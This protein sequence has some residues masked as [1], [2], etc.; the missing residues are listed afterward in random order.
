MIAGGGRQGSKLFTRNY[1]APNIRDTR[2]RSVF[3]TTARGARIILP[4]EVHSGIIP[5]YEWANDGHR[6]ANLA[7]KAGRD[8]FFKDGKVGYLQRLANFQ[9]YLHRWSARTMSVTGIFNPHLVIGFPGLVID[10]SLPNPAVLAQ[11]EELLGRKWMPVQYLGKMVALSHS[12][13]QGGGQTSAQFTH[14][15]T[16]RGLD[17][18][19]LS[20]LSRETLETRLEKV[21]VHINV[22]ELLGIGLTSTIENQDD[23]KTLVRKYMEG[24][25]SVDKPVRGTRA[26][27]NYKVASIE[28]S[29]E[30]AEL[31]KSEAAEFG[32]D[33]NTT[34]VVERE[35][36]NEEVVGS[37]E[38]EAS[39]LPVFSS[40]PK[41]I[42]TEVPVLNVPAT[43]TF[44]L[45]RS[46]KIGDPA[47][48][49]ETIESQLTP[50]W[51][52]DLWTN[53][54]ISE[55]V[56]QPLLGTDAIVENISLGADA[57]NE[58]FDRLKKDEDIVIAQD[59]PEGE[60]EKK[61]F[62]FSETSS[63][64]GSTAKLQVIPGSIE[65]AI[66]SIV[67]IYSTLHL[68]DGDVHDFIRKYTERPVANIEEMLG[69]YGLEFDD[70]GSV[71]VPQG[72]DRPIEGFHS[73]AFGDYNTD[74]KLPT[75][76][77][78]ETQAGKDALKALFTGAPGA[79]VSRGRVSNKKKKTKIRPELDPRGR[80]RTRVL[81]YVRELTLSRG[82]MG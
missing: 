33:P 40:E 73:R 74:V 79:T 30:T 16:H 34:A 76:E 18:E 8:P 47:E 28:A 13:N 1:L 54:N 49:K 68:R 70:N 61:E 39:S 20:A 69:T 55:K 65:E 21:A 43:F 10:R 36:F 60:G 59:P 50:G 63:I 25:L 82:L 53:K 5:K 80:A 14:C 42:Q 48:R 12:V 58:F 62:S 75:K 38:G 46:V 41:I 27:R 3:T 44:N 71:L 29:P 9:F 4:H 6:W 67:A 31:S 64:E 66:D 37:G 45:E 52:S 57:Q 2:G 32:L 77:G 19:F 15:R 7:K 51:F 17:D 23:K 26:W 24:S 11:R 72:E 22:R 81:A 35:I 78:Q 56:Y